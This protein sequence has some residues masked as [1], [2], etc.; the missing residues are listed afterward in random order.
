M[1][2]LYS[3]LRYP[4]GKAKVLNFMKE[5]L[6]Q[7]S[8]AKKPVYVEPY[9]GGAA[10]ALGLLLEGHVSKIYI[11][12]YDPAIYSFWEYCIKKHP[13][14]FI[15][16][17]RNIE[18]TMNE[19]HKQVAVYNNPKRKEGFNLGFAAFFLNRCNRSGI[20]KGGV[21]GGLAQ[22]GLYKI[23]CRF[24]K[25]NLISRIKAI[26]KHR[27]QI[28]IY[29]EDTKDF[30][31]RKDMRKILS[32]CL[33][34]LDPPY[35]KKGCQLYKNFYKHEDH[36]EIADIMRTLDGNWIV[37]YD[38][39]TEIQNLYKGFKQLEFNLI[40]FAGYRTGFREKNG[41][42]IMFFSPKITSI[43]N[44]KFIDKGSDNVY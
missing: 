31:R 40:Y 12:D 28:Y 33:L 16:K 8:F 41:K 19:W 1:K 11:N 3:P 14:K 21:I 44:L 26:S 39:Q 20:I 29:K 25:E 15:K 10:V 5:L 37:S 4:G 24:N 23:D 35:Y 22:V 6:K 13:F 27:S 34:Y 36:E 32:N 42:E 2:K 7:N 17:I 9:A 43:P 38:N 30:L 18:I